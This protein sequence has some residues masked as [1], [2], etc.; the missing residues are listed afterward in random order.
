MWCIIKNYHTTRDTVRRIL[1]TPSPRRKVSMPFMVDLS[2][3]R[4]RADLLTYWWYT[5]VPTWCCWLCN[6]GNQHKWL[7]YIMKLWHTG[8]QHTWLLYTNT[9]FWHSHLPW[10]HYHQHYFFLPIQRAS[11]RASEQACMHACMEASEQVCVR[12][13]VCM[14]AYTHVCMCVYIHMS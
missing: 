11:E 1:F 8:D 2:M 4:V 5:S 10:Q 12:A 9:K 3:G 13:C 7:Q 6:T 14:Y